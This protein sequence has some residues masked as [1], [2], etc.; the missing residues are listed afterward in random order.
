MYKRSFLIDF[1][2]FSLGYESIAELLIQNR[3][4]VDIVN[5]DGESALILAVKNGKK[6]ISLHYSHVI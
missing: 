4:N 1:I 3:A 6:K 2:T 5:N